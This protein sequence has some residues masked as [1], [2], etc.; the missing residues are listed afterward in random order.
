MPLH[1]TI[2]TEQRLMIAVAEGDVTRAEV[3][4]YLDAIVSAGALTYHKVFDASKGDTSMNADDLL[5]L[6]VRVRS[7]HALGTMGA[8]AIVVPPGRGKRLHRAFGM[9]AVADRPMRIF[10]EAAPAYRWIEQQT[11]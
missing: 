9:L 7:F 6:G 11:Y 1:W 2:D 3:E 8:L 5:P 10:D 4:D